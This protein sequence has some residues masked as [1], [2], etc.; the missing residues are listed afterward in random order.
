MQTL[1]ARIE[2]RQA[3]EKTDP[4]RSSAVSNHGVSET[5]WHCVCAVEATASR[6][7]WVAK[8][9]KITVTTNKT[10][11]HACHT[12]T[13][14]AFWLRCLA[15]CREHEYKS[16]QFNTSILTPSRACACQESKIQ[17]Y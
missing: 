6:G 15:H 16:P 13:F 11:V 4:A 9:D 7:I 10:W 5:T 3:V 17:N 12:Y 1:D 2:F 8:L 14:F